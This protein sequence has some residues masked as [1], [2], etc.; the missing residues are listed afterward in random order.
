EGLITRDQLY[1]ALK[2]QVD[3]DLDG[4]SHR[5]LGEILVQQGAMMWAQVGEVLEILGVLQDVFEP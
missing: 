5:P 1:E 3:D 4:G 2:A